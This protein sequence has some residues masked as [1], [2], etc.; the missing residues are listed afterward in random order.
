[1]DISGADA[2]DVPAPLQDLQLV[3]RASRSGGAIDVDPAWLVFGPGGRLPLGDTGLP[4]L[5]RIDAD[6]FVPLGEVVR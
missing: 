6:R 1:M 5:R 2:H 4:M 3:P